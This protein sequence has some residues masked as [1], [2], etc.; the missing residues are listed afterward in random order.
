MSVFSENIRNREG[1]VGMERIQWRRRV[2]FLVCGREMVVVREIVG[3]LSASIKEKKKK[4]ESVEKR[5]C[6]QCVG[7]RAK[8]VM[9]RGE[10]LR[11]RGRGKVKFVHEPVYRIRKVAELAWNLGKA[12]LPLTT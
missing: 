8:E 7:V 10:F 3:S 1:S 6:A 4:V 11:E 9:E 5:V 2:W 12:P